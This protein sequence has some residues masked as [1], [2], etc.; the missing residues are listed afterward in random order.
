MLQ[1][2]ACDT[3][4]NQDFG[5]VT[6]QNCGA[7]LIV[8]ISGDVRMSADNENPHSDEQLD[9]QL[10][11]Q[12]EITSQKNHDWDH[13]KIKESEKKNESIEEFQNEEFDDVEQYAEE[14]LFDENIKNNEEINNQ[15]DFENQN[16]KNNESDFQEDFFE[17]QI[18]EKEKDL[19]EFTE[20]TTSS[21][22]KSQKEVL[23]EETEGQNLPTEEQINKGENSENTEAFPSTSQPNS[24]PLD[25][26]EFAN[27]ETSNMD[28][29]EYL[30]DLTINH[31]DSKDLREALKEILTDKKLKINNDF[32][33]KIKNGRMC[34]TNLNPVKAKKIVEQLQF[35]DLNIY[36]KQKRVVIEENSPEMEEEEIF[37]EEISSD[38]V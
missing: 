15:N 7:V 5:M 35:Y 28:D 30:Y 18:D 21:E 29:G 11:E 36:W 34:I 33:K 2:P 6:C 20:E 19:Y 26:T 10:D 31:L 17:S 22:M 24:N 8:E 4:L 25:I 13:S 27:S 3:N 12:N 9:E 37:D 32:F 38:D 14:P 1:C 16:I 23:S